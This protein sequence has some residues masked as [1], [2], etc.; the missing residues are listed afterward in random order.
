MSVA[1]GWPGANKYFWGSLLQVIL[2]S[3]WVESI[4]VLCQKHPPFSHF[5][6]PVPKKPV[7]TE[8]SFDPLLPFLLSKVV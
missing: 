8:V 6:A 7:F 3:S 5:I 2:S 4:V 1:V